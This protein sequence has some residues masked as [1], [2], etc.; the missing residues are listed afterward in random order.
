MLSSLASV[1]RLISVDTLIAAYLM[2]R[3]R[4]SLQRRHVVELQRRRSKF[5]DVA[6]RKCFRDCDPYRPQVNY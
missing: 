2:S 1:S 5:V 6:S 3:A 4:L